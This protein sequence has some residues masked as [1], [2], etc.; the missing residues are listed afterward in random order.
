MMMHAWIISGLL[1][2]QPGDPAAE[3][4]DPAAEDPGADLVSEDPSAASD[5]STAEPPPPEVS[6][7]PPSEKPSEPPPPAAEEKP[8]DPAQLYDGGVKW[9]FG[10][11]QQNSLRLLTWHQI[12]ARYTQMNPGSQVQGVDKEHQFD[13]GIRRSRFLFLGQFAGRF[14]ILTHIGINNQTFNNAR[15]P[16]IFVHE[17]VGEV[18]VFKEYLYF[19]AGLHYWHGISRMTNASTISFLGLDAPILN[20]P[21]IERSD[22]FARKLGFYAKG[23]VG[24]F[25][26]RF[27]VNKPFSLG[28]GAEEELPT[29]AVAV[30]NPRANTIGTAG[31]FMLQFLDQESN[32]LPY[33]TG[34]YLGTKRVANLGVGFQWENDG[35]WWLD[36][37]GDVQT[38]DTAQVGVDVFVDMPMPKET[39]AL[40]FYGVYYW[41]F[42]GPD[43]VRMVGIM[44]LATGGNTLNGAGNAYPTMG[45]GHHVYAQIGYMLPFRNMGVNRLQPYFSGQL[46]VFE[47]FDR[48]GVAA[49]EFTFI[50]EV[51]LNWHL[52]GHYFKLT[53]AYRNRPVYSAS[54]EG[55]ATVSARLSEF[56]FQTQVAF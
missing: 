34:T 55:Y 2:F 3:Q 37:E 44:N 26:Y 36:G 45:S 18:R 19:G 15:K 29:T 5:A 51:G 54:D 50:P 13:I 7:P 10:A 11:R 20:W 12:W 53:A 31:Y 39:G 43:Y 30:E 9:T 35:V 6:A 38:Q 49:D 4:T 21:T 25:D 23:K 1:L 8:T 42:F 47:A 27:A 32:V 33:T 52:L 24:L 28:T 48:P 22:Q 46:S 17:A 14:L 41:H 16:Q 40:T 56:I